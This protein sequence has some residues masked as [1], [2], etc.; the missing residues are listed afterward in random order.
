MNVISSS[1]W[2]LFF[3]V[4]LHRNE[5][6]RPDMQNLMWYRL[7]AFLGGINMSIGR[8]IEPI[9]SRRLETYACQDYSVS[10]LTILYNWAQ[11]Y[12][13]SLHARNWYLKHV[14]LTLLTYR[15]NTPGLHQDSTLPRMISSVSGIT[16]GSS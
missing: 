15:G 5:C 1:F 8:F 16:K 7:E 9:E 2:F 6:P 11:N 4:N 13:F 10:F 12:S 14:S 3:A